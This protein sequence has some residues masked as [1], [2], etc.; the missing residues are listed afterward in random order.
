MV[1]TGQAFAGNDKEAHTAPLFVNGVMRL[2]GLHSYFIFAG[3][4]FENM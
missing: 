4:D 3:G 1:Q 2:S